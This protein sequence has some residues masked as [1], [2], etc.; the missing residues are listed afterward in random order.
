MA[1]GYAAYLLRG[2]TRMSNSIRPATPRADRVRVMTWNLWWRYGRWRER[3]EA[4]VAEVRRVVPDVCGLQEVWTEPGENLAAAFADELGWYFTYAPSPAPERWQH[5]IGDASVGIGNAVL[6][7]WPIVASEIRRLPAGDEPDEGRVVLYAQ[8]E[9]PFG[10][11]PFFTTHLNTPW[12]Q[13]ALR[14]EQVAEIA[15]FMREHASAFPPI[16]TGD[17]N[18]MAD[19]DEIRCI[20]GKTVPPVR[21]FVLLD[22]W[23]YARPLEPGWTWDRRN[24]HVAA[25]LEPNA[26][27]DYVFVGL[28][29]DGG[30]GHVL[31]VELIGTEPRHGVWASDHF[32]IL[33][34]LRG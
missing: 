20:V 14:R 32:G 25:T 9:S 33:A 34:E 23:S 22:A 1:R 2:A 29:T 19:Y 18:A 17:F 26:R 3:R 5:K 24:P 31:D 11:I 4:I 7:R 12:G 21:G 6:S 27:I 13:S 8:I 30:Q 16:L 10:R 15:E 28:P